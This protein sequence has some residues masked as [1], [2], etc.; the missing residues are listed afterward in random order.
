MA[1]RPVRVIAYA[2]GRGEERPR[3]FFLGDERL[4]VEEVMR[5]WVEEGMGGEGRRRSFRVRASDGREHLIFYHEK[6]KA[7]FHRVGRKR[8]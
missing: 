4:E 3:T 2:G 8:P 7:W 5:A 1:E 6:L